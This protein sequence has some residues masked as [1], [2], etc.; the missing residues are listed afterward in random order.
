M[1]DP[2]IGF[3]QT[4][5][6]NGSIFL[7]VDRQHWEGKKPR[8]E[9]WKAHI[10]FERQEVLGSMSRQAMVEGLFRELVGGKPGR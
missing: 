6:G 2:W 1:R 8:C 10:L 9:E 3:K 7:E 4:Q 5:V